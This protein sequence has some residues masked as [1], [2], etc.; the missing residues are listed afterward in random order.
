MFNQQSVTPAPFNAER[1]NRKAN[2]AGRT[3]V[4]II[5]PFAGQ[6]GE[7]RIGENPTGRHGIQQNVALA[8]PDAIQPIPIM[9]WW[10]FKP[11]ASISAHDVPRLKRCIRGFEIIGDLNWRAAEAGDVP[12]A[13]AVAIRLVK[14]GLV[15]TPV[16]NLAGTALLIAAIKVDATARLMIEYL[17]GLKTG[18]CLKPYQNQPATTVHKLQQL[19]T[20]KMEACS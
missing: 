20:A 6:I 2:G 16:M 10:K 4:K 15:A 12:A 9:E 5:A 14:Q 19:I 3:G 8:G 13:I 7:H 17:A 1:G 11:L 18:D